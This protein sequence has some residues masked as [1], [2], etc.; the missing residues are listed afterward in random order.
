[1]LAC[2]RGWQ[3]IVVL[4][5]ARLCMLITQALNIACMHCM[6]TFCTTSVLSHVFFGSLIIRMCLYDCAHMYVLVCSIPVWCRVSSVLAGSVEAGSLWWVLWPPAA[7]SSYPQ[8][9]AVGGLCWCAWRPAA[10][11]QRWQLSQSH[12]HCQPSTQAVPAEKR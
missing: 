6:Q 5:S 3:P 9:G 10:H 2:P 4:K 11:Q 12:L 7:R 1:M 8:C